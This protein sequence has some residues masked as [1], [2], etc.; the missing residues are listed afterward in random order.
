MK[1]EGNVNATFSCNGL[2][3]SHDNYWR[4]VVKWFS[5][6]RTALGRH[7]QRRKIISSV[8]KDIDG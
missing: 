2:R 4:K 6:A 1:K 5:S 8:R 3:L 7:S